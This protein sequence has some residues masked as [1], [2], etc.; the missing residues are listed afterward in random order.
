MLNLKQIIK[1][2]HSTCH[3]DDIQGSHDFV[4]TEKEAQGEDR[5]EGGDHEPRSQARD[6]RAARHLQEQDGTQDE[7]GA[8]RPQTHDGDGE[9]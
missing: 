2:C 7:A 5:T 9:V 4:G 8:A 3:Y 1:W 6:W